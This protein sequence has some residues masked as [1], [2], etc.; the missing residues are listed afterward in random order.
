MSAVPLLCTLLRM[1]AVGS[2]AADNC[3]CE[4]VTPVPIA[5]LLCQWLLYGAGGFRAAHCPHGLL[6][7]ML[8]LTL[9]GYCTRTQHTTGTSAHSTGSST[10]FCPLPT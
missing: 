6:T 9:K 1:T 4:G 2:K 3:V 10:E 7:M 8:S 5:R